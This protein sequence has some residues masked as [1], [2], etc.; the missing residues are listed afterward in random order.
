MLARLDLYDFEEPLAP[1]A[2]LR[3]QGL[4]DVLLL[5]AI[6]QF[7]KHS[8]LCAFQLGHTHSAY[9]PQHC[10]QLKSRGLSVEAQLQG[11]AKCCSEIIAFVH[12]VNLP[13]TERVEPYSDLLTLGEERL[14]D[15]L[16]DPGID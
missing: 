15:S 8:L 6:V 10:F 5:E 9:H 2:A 14:E 11:L 7:G 3:C 1:S 12:S 13:E 16:Q 4:Q